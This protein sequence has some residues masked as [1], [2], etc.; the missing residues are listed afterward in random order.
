MPC[1]HAI[2]Q[3]NHVAPFA[4]RQSTGTPSSGLTT[5]KALLYG[6]STGLVIGG[7]LVYA[8]YNPSFH[9]KADKYVP[10]FARLADFT[11]DRWMDLSDTVK[12]TSVDRVG[13]KKDLG[14][15]LDSLSHEND[16]KKPIPSMVD[17]K[18][19]AKEDYSVK[20]SD[21]DESMLRQTIEATT[22]EAVVQP[23][24][25]STEEFINTATKYVTEPADGDSV[26]LAIKE[27]SIDKMVA[28]E[29]QPGILPEIVS[30][31]SCACK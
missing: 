10:G 22:H 3:A 8:S 7:S 23:P 16:T 11:A 9:N 25:L 19:Q 4:R 28:A 21:K 2:P 5:W 26:Q 20:A 12:P 24:T 18:F 1:Y 31:V 27:E 29:S 6:M 14:S 30:I 17:E 13:L 15:Q